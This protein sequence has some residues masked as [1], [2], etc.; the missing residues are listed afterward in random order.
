MVKYFCKSSRDRYDIPATVLPPSN[1]FQYLVYYMKNGLT[2]CMIS[3]MAIAIYPIVDGNLESLLNSSADSDAMVSITNQIYFH[4]GALRS[5]G[6]HTEIS[7]DISM[8]IL[9][10][11]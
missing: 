11:Q 1:L 7:I 8:K 6:P 2:L 9:S 3:I 5:E 4:L 10:L